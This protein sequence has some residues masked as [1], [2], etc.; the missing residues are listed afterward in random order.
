MAKV[1]IAECH[2]SMPLRSTDGVISEEDTEQEWHV[3]Q[4]PACKAA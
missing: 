1:V 2:L 3:H 4:Q